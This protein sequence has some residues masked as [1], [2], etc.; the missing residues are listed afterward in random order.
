M[1]NKIRNVN[2]EFWN[3]KGVL[4]MSNELIDFLCKI[5]TWE[6]NET[7]FRDAIVLSSAKLLLK[8]YEEVDDNNIVII[9][10]LLR[11]VKEN[12]VLISGLVEGVLSAEQF[13][14]DKHKPAD[15]MNL[16]KAKGLEIKDSEF[17]FFNNYLKSIK[18]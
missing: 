14:K 11:Q 15:I 6:N 5:E 1:L 7:F 13:I 16:I 9:A 3:Y 17:D 18:K 8:C 12:L 10:P 4:N 2:S